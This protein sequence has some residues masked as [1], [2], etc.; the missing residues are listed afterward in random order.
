MVRP[1]VSIPVPLENNN[2]V[3][4]CFACLPADALGF[5][6]VPDCESNY[7]SLMTYLPPVSGASWLR[8]DPDEARAELAARLAEAAA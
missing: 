1:S 2:S 5:A 4:L 3:F 8:G 6:A 7:H